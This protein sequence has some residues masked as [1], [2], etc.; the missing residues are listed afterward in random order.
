MNRTIRTSLIAS[1][2]ALSALLG[3]GTS[4]ASA[5]ELGPLNVKLRYA[6]QEG[7]GTNSPTLEAGISDHPI[8][9][10][11]AEGRTVADLAVIG[12][13]TDDDDR[14]WPVRA[15]N[16]PIEW[17]KEVLAKNAGDWGIRVDDGAPVTL[18]GKLTRFRVIE[19]NKAVGSTYNAEAQF[20]FELRDRK[21]GL[22]WEGTGAGDATRYGKA[23][24]EDN[25]NEVFSDA[26]QEAFASALADTKLQ[27]AW[28]GKS[29]P[30]ST[31][32]MAQATS[33]ERKAGD[34]LTPEA[35]L[36]ELVKLQ[37]KG[38]DADLLVGFVDQKGLSRSLSS[39][40]LLAWKN[41]GM[42]DSVIKAALAKGK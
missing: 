22:L 21:G 41:A 3:L 6:P 37:K 34:M 29:G 32:A 17:S 15:T 7:V 26:A 8:R 31:P 30:M 12:E 14:V 10:E 5:K 35:M 13:S 40:D 23:R 11:M 25:V 20:T 16:D 28:L 42:P 9:V 18:V 27:E 1:T 38:F 33:S 36:E 24:S 39:D 19:S 4:A 2:L